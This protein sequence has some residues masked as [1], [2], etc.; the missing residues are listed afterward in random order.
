M[1]RQT[2]HRTIGRPLDTPAS[3]FELPRALADLRA[4]AALE[5]EGRN[6]IILHKEDGLKVVLIAM[7][8]GNEIRSHRA[9]APITLQALEGRVAVDAGGKTYELRSGQL[10]TLHAGLEHAVRALEESAFLLTL[11]GPNGH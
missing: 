6:S 1:E 11:A 5:R 8:A 4:E 7:R 3:R 2:L 10:L 9:A